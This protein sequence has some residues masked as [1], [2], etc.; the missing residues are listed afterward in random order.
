MECFYFG[1]SSPILQHN[2]WISAFRPN[3]SSL[4]HFIE[5]FR[6]FIKHLHCN[7]TSP[8]VP[9]LTSPNGSLT[10]HS[11]TITG[12]R[13]PKYVNTWSFLSLK[14]WSNVYEKIVYFKMS[15]LG[16]TLLEL[17]FRGNRTMTQ[18]SLHQG[19]KRAFS[20]LII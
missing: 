7:C 18:I 12:W 4:R 2:I 11:H 16:L 6:V 15:A 1:R 14:S 9:T 10:T 3:H 5:H 17:N 20:T 13:F 19:S 8:Q